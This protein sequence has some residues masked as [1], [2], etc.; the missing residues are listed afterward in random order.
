MEPQ[1]WALIAGIASPA[2]AIQLIES[3]DS[4]LLTELGYM[5]LSP[6]YTEFD[7]GIGRISSMEPGIAENGTIYTH[8][9]IWMILGLL[10]MG[11]ADKAY[12]VFK[13]ITPCSLSGPEDP[14]RKASFLYANC[15]Y[16]PQHKS[17]PFQQQFTWITGSYAWL[18]TVLIN[19]WIGAKPDYA[20]LRVDPCL[21]AAWPEASIVRTWRGTTYDI[22][23]RNPH[24]LERGRVELVVD[25]KPLSGN[26]LPAFADDKIHKVVATML[27]QV[28]L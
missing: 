23:I 25:G 12:D 5:L 15:Y 6:A 3:C 18:N 7:P 4:L 13:R 16:G 26:L 2:R 28:A 9:N 8:L 24:L 19:E 27:P 1:C 11:K 20:G 14:K 22:Q 10:R 17:R 21:P